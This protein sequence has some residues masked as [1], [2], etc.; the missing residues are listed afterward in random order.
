MH[1]TEEQEAFREELRAYLQ[2]EVEPVVDEADQEPFT[3]DEM[4]KYMKDLEELGIGF[5]PDTVTEFFGDLRRFAIVSEEISYYW[6]SLNVGLMMGFPAQFVRF[7]SEETQANQLSK[8]ETGE[9]IGSLAVTE[10]EGGS[11]TARP[12]TVARKE[13]NE[14]VL[15]GG[16]TWVGNAPI[17]DV[18]LVV[19]HDEEADTQDMFLIDREYSD[20]EAETLN[21]IGWKAVNNGRMYLDGVRVPEDNKLSAIIGNAIRDGNQITDVV[22]FPDSVAELFFDQKALN[23]TFS[24][25]RTGMSFMSVGIMQAAFDEVVDYVE[26]RETFGKPIAEHQLVQELLYDIR[27]DLETSRQ[28]S[29]RALE[30]LENGSS[31]ARLL[32]SMAKGYTAE[33]AHEATSNAIQVMGGEGLKTENRLERYFRDAR[34]MPIPDGTTEIQKLIVGKEITGRSAYN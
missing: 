4:V 33:K 7:A 3:R 17:A 24:F 12:E 23:A 30:S 16:K 5:S 15:E 13:G 20:Y 19:A 29:R 34:V 10:P 31:D 27:V 18:S 2:R 6:P 25:M 11:D 32:S 26:E 28:L 21:K 14:Y 8:L 1:L 9:C 22:P